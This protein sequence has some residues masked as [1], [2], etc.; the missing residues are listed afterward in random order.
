MVDMKVIE[1]LPEHFPAAMYGELCSVFGHGICNTDDDGV[2]AITYLAGTGGWVVAFYA[3]CDKLD[4]KWLIEYYNKLEWTDSDCFDSHI[5][6]LVFEN[7]P[8]E[9]VSPY[10]VYL[11]DKFN[12][13]RFREV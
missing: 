11:V 3:T 10:Y 4:M 5:A 7:R 12:L 8:G 1:Q 2:P 6:Q 9:L 13:D